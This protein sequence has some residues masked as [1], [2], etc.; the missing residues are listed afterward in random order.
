LASQVQVLPSAPRDTS[1]THRRLRDRRTG[2]TATTQPAFRASPLHWHGSIREARPAL[3]HRQRRRKARPLVGHFRH[4]YPQLC[5]AAFVGR[6]ARH[7]RPRRDS[8][9]RTA[10]SRIPVSEADIGTNRPMGNVR[11]HK[12]EIVGTV[13]P[14]S[15]G[16]NFL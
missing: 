8:G 11:C 13:L 1:S 5:R 2:A 12:R 3:R 6:A 15:K 4:F 9:M 7:R 10:N 16:P 14:Q